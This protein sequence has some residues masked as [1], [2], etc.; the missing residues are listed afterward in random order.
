MKKLKFQME[1]LTCPSCIKKIER[2]LLKR[3]SIE[4]V[5]VLFHSGKVKVEYDETVVT[6]NE[7]EDL[8]VKLGYPVQSKQIA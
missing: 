2:S 3:Q 4:S 6:A 5:Q 1:P 7:I 8:L